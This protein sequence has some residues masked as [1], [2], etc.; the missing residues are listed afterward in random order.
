MKKII[1]IASISVIIFTNVALAAKYKSAVNGKYVKSG[2]A[3]S[4]KN[5]TY[6]TKR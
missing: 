4:N 6:K 1:A 3:K 5:T 2:Y